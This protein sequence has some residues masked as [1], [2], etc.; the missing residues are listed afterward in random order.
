MS[1]IKPLLWVSLCR[2]SWCWVAW[3]RIFSQV[4]C[5]RLWQKPLPFDGKIL[6]PPEP[7]KS[8]KLL[9]GDKRFSLSIQWRWKKV[10]WHWSLLEGAPVLDL[11]QEVAEEGAHLVHLGLGEL[12]LV[13]GLA[14]N[15]NIWSI[16]LLRALAKPLSKKWML[17]VVEPS[18]VSSRTKN[19]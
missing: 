15:L 11:G 13:S 12:E 8:R 7:W 4:W 3:R 16:K 9:G 14:G 19:A 1:Q 2:K 5:S 6:A 10:L 17:N 18:L